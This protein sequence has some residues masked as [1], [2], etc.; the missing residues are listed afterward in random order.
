MAN[1][2]V[3]VKLFADDLKIYSISDYSDTNLLQKAIDSTSSWAYQNKLLFSQDKIQHLNIGKKSKVSKYTLNGNPIKLVNCVRDLGI[4]VDDKLK[5]NDHIKGLVRNANMR[6]YHLLRTL[7]KGLPINLQ[8]IAYKSYIRPTLEYATEI[9]N[10]SNIKNIKKLEKVQRTFTKR[11]LY[12]KGI[13]NTPYHK[14]LQMCRLD[15][16]EKRRAKTDLLTTFK[17]MHS[18]FDVDPSMLFTLSHRTCSR[19]HHLSLFKPR[20]NNTAQKF[21]S[22]RIINS[23][24]KLPKELNAIHC[25][26]NFKSFLEKIPESMLSDHLYFNCERSNY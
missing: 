17:I 3:Y 12:N 22:N 24:N 14:R 21:F 2:D 19:A 4:M 10:P 7:P 6:Q 8:T 13:K 15:P 23:W 5:F 26:K 20:C 9:F 25:E 16:L 1:P 18:L 11:I